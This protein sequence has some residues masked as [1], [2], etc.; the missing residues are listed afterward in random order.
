MFRSEGKLPERP[1]FE[2]LKHY[3]TKRV[4]HYTS[5]GILPG[6]GED[7][8]RIRSKSQ[9]VFLKPK[10][11]ENYLPVLG[12][13]SD[14]FIDRIRLIRQE[15]DEMKPDFINEMY[16]WALECMFEGDS[17]NFN[18]FRAEINFILIHCQLLRWSVSTL[19]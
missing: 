17:Y 4:E 9:P 10:N 8:W 14:E 13:I 7:W 5:N 3:R 19:D 18:S 2:A 15:N 11:I 12:Q 16:R 1:G 6:N